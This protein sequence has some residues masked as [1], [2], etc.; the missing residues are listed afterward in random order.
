MADAP[1]A[2]EA[3]ARRISWAHRGEAWLAAFSIR[4]LGLLPL[5]WASALGGTLARTIGPR[6]GISKRARLN[7]KIAMPELGNAEIRAIVRGMWDNLGRVVF[8]YPHLA[9]ITVYPAELSDGRV[10]VCGVEH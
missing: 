4:V 5:D 3:P 1:L 8:E 9:K 7:L 2:P 6:L 10:E